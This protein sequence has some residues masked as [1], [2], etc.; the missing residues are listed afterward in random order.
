MPTGSTS[1]ITSS[2]TRRP[3]IFTPSIAPVGGAHAAADLR[4]LERRPGRRGGGHDAVLVAERDLR[5]RADVD[6]QPQALVA[7]EAGGE[8]ARDD[9][10][11]DVGAQRRERERR[12]AR[13]HRA[14][15]SRPPP[16]AAARAS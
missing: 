4:G 10:A 15:R 14:R 3:A 6:E 16:A 12:R 2:V 1:P 11:A 8:H 9:V 13:V 7:R 5:V